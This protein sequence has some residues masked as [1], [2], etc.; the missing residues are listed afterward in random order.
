MQNV[1]TP[2]KMKKVNELIDLLERAISQKQNL[3]NCIGE[4]QQIIWNAQFES[5][6]VEER[7]LG[8][9]GLYPGLPKGS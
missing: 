2:Y 7:I 1:S 9:L 6:E 5:T 8:D 3:I 4:F